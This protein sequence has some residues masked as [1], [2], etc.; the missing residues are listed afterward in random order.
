MDDHLVFVLFFDFFPGRNDQNVI[1]IKLFE[2]FFPVVDPV[3]IFRLIHGNTALADL[4]EHPQGFQFFFYLRKNLFFCF[5]LA[6]YR[7]G[8]VFCLFHKET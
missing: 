8:S 7:K 4:T 6:I 2:V 5:L 3:D 1:H